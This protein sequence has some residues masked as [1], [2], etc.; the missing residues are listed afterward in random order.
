MPK[1]EVAVLI[2]ILALSVVIAGAYVS[3]AQQ[4]F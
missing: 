1:V 4:C 2:G 3:M